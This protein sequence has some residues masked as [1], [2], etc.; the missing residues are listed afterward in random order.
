MLSLEMVLSKK[1]YKQYEVYE[2]NLD[3]TLG[4]GINKTRPAV[5]VS[6]TDMNE[7]LETVVICPLTTSL[8]PEWRTRLQVICKRKKAD[9]CVDQIRTVSKTRLVKKLDVITHDKAHELR[10][11]ISDLYGAVST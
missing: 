1:K 7:A 9:I 5:I 3:P 11:I 2:V 10:I 4:S 8:H 6:K